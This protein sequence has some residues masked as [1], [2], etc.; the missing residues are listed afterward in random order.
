[1]FP[2]QDRAL[3]TPNYVD[4]DWSKRPRRRCRGCRANK[5]AN[6]GLRPEECYAACSHPLCH[7]LLGATADIG[8]L[9]E[10]ARRFPRAN[11]AVRTGAA[12]NLFVLD[13]DG[14]EG[15][16]RLAFLEAENCPLNPTLVHRTGGGTRHLLFD[17]PT[18]RQNPTRNDGAWRNSARTVLG[19]GLDT[20]GEGGYVVLPGSN[21]R[22]GAY[23][24]GLDRPRGQVN[25]WLL[26]LLGTRPAPVADN[27]AH[28]VTV[29]T[30]MAPGNGGTAGLPGVHRYAASCFLSRVADFRSITT[31]GNG[32][33][34]LLYGAALYLSGIANNPGGVES[35]LTEA[36]IRDALDE[37]AQSN[38]YASTRS[39]HLD[40]ID[41]GISQGRTMPAKNWPPVDRLSEADQIVA[42][43]IRSGDQ[44]LINIIKT[45]IGN[46][47]YERMA[48]RLTGGT[49]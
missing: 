5:L 23:Q 39:D 15:E 46:S 12:S 40:T 10:W 31:E 47:E 9:I 8:V 43:A 32:R 48:A 28:S 11:T 24:V 37:A 38:G 4:E 42:D 34:R 49:A 33:S 13:E 21:S 16:E 41:N 20:R 45:N 35:G 1:V 2:L 18:H 29:L 30:A 7:G 14:R 17:Y 26:D 3:T 27:T 22:K 25:G 44:A 6:P 19:A 36:M